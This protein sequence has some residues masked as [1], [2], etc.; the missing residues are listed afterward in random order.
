LKPEETHF[1]SPRSKLIGASP[2]SSRNAS[3]DSALCTPLF[4]R[5]STLA[6]VG[7]LYAVSPWRP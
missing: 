7:A 1:S 5:L 2:P 6:N 3:R 4:P